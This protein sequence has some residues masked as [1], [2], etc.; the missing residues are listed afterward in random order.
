MLL[1]FFSVFGSY[2]RAQSLSQQ[3]KG[4]V[5]DANNDPVIGASIMVKN[6]KE[7]TVTDM[8]G[9]FVLNSSPAATLVVSYIGY[10]TQEVKTEGRKSPI[11]IVLKEDTKRLGEVVVTALGIKRDRK[12]LGYSLGEV[13]GKE[14]QKVKE[15]N[16]INSLAGK[17][18]GLTVS[19]TATG[20]SGST[21]VILRG[22]TTSRSMSL[23]VC[24]WTTPILIA[25]TSGVATIWVMEYRV[26]I[27]TI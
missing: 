19:Q 14:L 26:L 15:P 25:P 11:T 17:V 23:T 8:E 21:R 3:L 6:S 27:L 10:V 20:P 2:A 4:R 13:N 24:L 16:V 9:K 18:A 7:G 5:I 12:A 22:S 1:T